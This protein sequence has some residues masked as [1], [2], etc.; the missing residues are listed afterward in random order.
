MSRTSR[1]SRRVLNVGGSNKA[2]GIPAYYA[3]FE[4]LLADIDSA[5]SPD[6]LIDARE[7]GA[8]ASAQFDVVYCS[9]N[10]EHFFAHDVPTVLSGFHH[11]LKQDGFAEIRVPDLAAVMQRVV[12][13]GLE[14]DDILYTTAAGHPIAV[15]DVI[16]GWAREIERSGTDFYAH[17][18]GFTPNTL[19]KALNA[20]NFA[21][22]I[23]RPGRQLEILAFAFKAM[24]NAVQRELLQLNIGD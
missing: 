18:T 24:P 13:D 4:H 9:H 1:S 20:A 16:Y 17:K 23:F 15:R 10:L 21:V 14:L 6:L 22:V 19:G 3:G 8:T 7:L 5:G 11:V 12:K 2:I